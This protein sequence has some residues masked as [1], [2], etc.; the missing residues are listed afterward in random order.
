MQLW[1]R[2]IFSPRHCSDLHP[3]HELIG[4]THLFTSLSYTPH[5]LREHKWSL[6]AESESHTPHMPDMPD[7]AGDRGGPSI[8]IL[9]DWSQKQTDSRGT[10]MTRTLSRKGPWMLGETLSVRLADSRQDHANP[11]GGISAGPDPRHCLA[12]VP[13]YPPT[14]QLL[15]NVCPAPHHRQKPI[16]IRPTTPSLSQ[17][18]DQSGLP[19]PGK[20]AQ[21]C[22]LPSMTVMPERA[23]ILPHHREAG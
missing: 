14:R 12:L 13:D 20:T 7:L 9:Y 17:Y 19:P 15:A 6:R 1:N 8:S 18:C 16:L 10:P 4:S 21:L 22:L 23:L 3:L 11:S 2:P 5:F